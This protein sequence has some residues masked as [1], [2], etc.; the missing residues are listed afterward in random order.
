M[1]NLFIN[2]SSFFFV[3]VLILLEIQEGFV[4]GDESASSG[5]V[6][7]KGTRF[8]LNGRPLYLNGF[9][10]YW[11]MYQAADTSTRDMISTTLQ[12]AKSKY[13]MNVVRTW[14]FSDGGYRALQKSPG[15]Y[16]E[17]VF[18]GLD[19]VI[20]EAKK[21]GIYLI[22]SLVNNWEGY[23]GKKQYVQW[24]RDNGHYLNS[25][26]DFFTDSVVKGYYKNHI[27][28]VL[29]RVNSFTGIAYKDEPTIFAWELMN[30]PRCQ[31]DLSGK[32]LQGWVSEMAAYVKSIDS[33]HLLEVGLEGFY[34]ES[35]PEK[36]VSNPGYEVGTDFI[37][38]NNIPHVD[39]TTIHLYPDQWT[40][41]DEAAQAQFVERWIKAHIE[42]SASV[43]GK[44][45]MLTEFGKSSRSSGYQVAVRDAYFSNIYDTLYSCAKSPSGV[46]G[47]SCFWQVMAPG[48][49][50]WG[51]GYEV[52]MDQ[53]PSTMAVVAKQ[54][55]RLESLS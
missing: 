10:A 38:N 46:C 36:R 23:G 30:E 51:D 49:E 9:N 37:A 1:K 20:S 42:D 2:C 21:N 29:N 31:S 43:L 52:F 8:M 6:Q 12:Q 18:R 55:S 27:K 40:N 54:S 11:M 24:A 22:L 15:S 35:M 26:D 7:T 17:E 5:F 16:D 3:T 45:L 14:A 28:T 44:P 41:S 19:F 47:G 4:H 53:S 39:F 50:N 25:E 13:G 33:N 34:G 32:S 48:M